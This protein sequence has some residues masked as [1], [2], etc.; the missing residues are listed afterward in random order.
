MSNFNE[1]YP[2]V[3]RRDVARML[4]NAHNPDRHFENG[5]YELSMRDHDRV[6]PILDQYTCAAYPFESAMTN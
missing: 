1:Q 2:I 4:P 3:T 6:M 5:D